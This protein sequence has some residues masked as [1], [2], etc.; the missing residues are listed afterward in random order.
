[1]R[2][3]RRGG[4]TAVAEQR[5]DMTKASSPFQA[6]GLQRRALRSESRLFFNAALVHHG[7]HGSLSAAAV[8][9]RGG[10]A[11][12][13][14]G[15]HGIG[16]QPTG[17]AMFA[18]QGAQCLIGQIRQRDET[19]LVALAAADMNQFALTVDIAHLQVQGL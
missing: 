12:T 9:V 17:V 13:L 15:A 10:A 7:F 4:G 18:P 19:I 5:L 2:V 8:H 14:G 1:M 3:A 11:N 6:D 16:E